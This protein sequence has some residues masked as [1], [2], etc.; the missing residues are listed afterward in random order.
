MVRSETLGRVGV[1]GRRLVAV[2]GVGSLLTLGVLMSG[3]GKSGQQAPPSTPTTT[4][5]TTTSVTV[6]PSTTDKDINPNGPNLF[7][8]PAQ[9]TPPERNP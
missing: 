5:T 1:G 4:T 9:F 2:A 6:T 3:C 8:P 7:T